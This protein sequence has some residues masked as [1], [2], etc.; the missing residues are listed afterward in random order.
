MITRTIHLLWPV[1]EVPGAV[2]ETP[3]DTPEIELFVPES[4]RGGCVLICPGGGYGHLATHERDPIAQWFA[5]HGVLAAALRYRLGPRYGA[6]TPL[7]DARRA[8]RFL[9]HHADSFGIDPKRVSALG[10]SAGGHLAATLAGAI[11]LKERPADDIDTQPY[12]P[13]ALML[14]YPVISMEPPLAHEGS[15]RNLLG[16]SASADRRTA[17]SAHRHVTATHPPTFIFHGSADR[18]VPVQ[19]AYVM[20]AALADAGVPC[21]MAIYENAPHGIGMKPEHG[22]ATRWREQMIDWLRGRGW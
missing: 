19:N 11:Q 17:W 12:R 4:H 9:R 14:A 21:E 13:D 2:G 6:P 16:E 8:V 20:A 15:C 3:D 5:G 1:G 7:T 18:S 10:F 22:R